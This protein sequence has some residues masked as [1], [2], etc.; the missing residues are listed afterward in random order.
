MAD[1]V[2]E[3]GRKTGPGDAFES[4]ANKIDAIF[5]PIAKKLTLVAMALV[6]LM[7]ISVTLDVSLKLANISFPWISEV[8]TYMMGILTFVALAYVGS[9]KGHISIDLLFEKLPE[10]LKAGLGTGHKILEL[11]LVVFMAWRLFVYAGTVTTL[12][13]SVLTKLPISVIVYIMFVGLVFYVPVIL[14][15]LLHNVASFLNNFSIPGL[16]ILAGL[17]V[18]VWTVPYWFAALGFNATMT[19]VMGIV[20]MLSLILS[21]LPLAFGLGTAG[22]VVFAKLTSFTSLFNFTGRALYSSVGDYYLAVIPFFVV[23]GSLV[24]V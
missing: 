20:L 15:D 9:I 7:I 5:H 21:G 24:A 17:P 18:A 19:G 8:V 16:V 12:T 6:V 13:G 22:A 10:K 14:G 2:V 23:M 11:I 4:L 1:A 3:A